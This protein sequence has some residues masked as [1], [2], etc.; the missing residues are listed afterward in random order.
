LSG[1]RGS[2]IPAYILYPP[3]VG[4]RVHVGVRVGASVGVGRNPSGGSVD[5]GP[6]SVSVGATVGTGTAGIAVG[7][8]LFTVMCTSCVTLR[9]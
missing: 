3:G 9:P 6:G 1:K 7:W 5:T 2:R 8:R 4:V